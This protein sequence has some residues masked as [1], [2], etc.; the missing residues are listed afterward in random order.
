[1]FERQSTRAGFI[2]VAG[3]AIGVQHRGLICL[4]GFC[5]ALLGSCWTEGQCG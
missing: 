3:D 4:S 5:L 1:M 2:A